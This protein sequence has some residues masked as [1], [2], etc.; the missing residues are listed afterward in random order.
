MANFFLGFPVPR[1]R[2]ADMIT[3]AAP[4]LEHTANHRPD[5]SDPLVLPGDISSGQLVKW[6]GSKFIGL[7][8]PQAGITF[9]WDDYH[10]HTHFESLDGFDITAN[11]NATVTLDH[12]ELLLTTDG[13]DYSFAAIKKEPTRPPIPLTWARPTSHCSSIV[14]GPKAEPVRNRSPLP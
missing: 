10:F 13:S 12:D 2:I 3:G 11:D 6:N 5:G 7:D 9:P 14:P 8:Q 1:A 4:P